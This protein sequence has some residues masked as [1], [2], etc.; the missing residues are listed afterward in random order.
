[1]IATSTNLLSLTAKELM[2]G[3]VVT[4]HQEM[5]IKDAALTLIKNNISGAPVVDR[6]GRCIGVFS[7]NDL[8]RSYSQKKSGRMIPVEQVITCPFVRAV[9]DKHGC[10]TS[11]CTLPLG[12]C[13]IQRASKDTEGDS[14]IV[15]SEPIRFPW[16]GVSWRS[17]NF[18]TTPFNVT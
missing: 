17:K 2:T 18:R 3:E 9:R 7:T 12:I 15:C 6:E 14:H 16:N 1:M 8:L 10:E 4:L 11:L 13:A 5:S